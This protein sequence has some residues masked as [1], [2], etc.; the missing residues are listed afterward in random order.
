[1]C[2]CGSMYV[3]MS[4]SVCLNYAKMAAFPVCAAQDFRKFSEHMQNNGR[5][6]NIYLPYRYIY[7]HIYITH[8]TY[9]C[10][11][12][13]PTE[14]EGGSCLPSKTPLRF[15]YVS[16]CFNFF[17]FLPSSKEIFSNSGILFYIY[18]YIYSSDLIYL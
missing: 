16:F 10:I 1:M 18:S 17:I 12:Y 4:V 13:M 6:Q 8:H 9:T 3:C 15:H 11:K 14:R 7:T 5:Q 2:V